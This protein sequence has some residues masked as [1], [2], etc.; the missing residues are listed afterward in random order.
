MRSQL[1]VSGSGATTFKGRVVLPASIRS[2]ARLA[3]ASSYRSP[4]KHDEYVTRYRMRLSKLQLPY[5]SSDTVVAAE[6]VTPLGQRHGMER[7]EWGT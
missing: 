5:W 3:K 6:H 1:S 7:T 4:N 2:I